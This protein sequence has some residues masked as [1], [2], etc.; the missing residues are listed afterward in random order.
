MTKLDLHAL[1]LCDT[2]STSERRHI[3]EGNLGGS[4]TLEFTLKYGGF[5]PMACPL[6]DL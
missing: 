2:R 4:Y 3:A 1:N 5:P 6:D